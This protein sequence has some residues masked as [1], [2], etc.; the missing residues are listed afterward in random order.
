MSR[1][2]ER[3]ATYGTR[4]AR[5]P[6]SAQRRGLGQVG[7]GVV[8]ALGPQV[9][10]QLAQDRAR[11]VLLEDRHRVDAGERGEDRGA[12]VLLDQ[13]ALRALEPAHGRVG[14]QAHDQAVAERPR[15]LERAHVAGVQEVEA[16]ARGHHR[17]ALGADARGQ[18]G[19][20]LGRRRARPG[21]VARP[22]GGAARGDEGG[23]G[24]HGRAHGLRGQRAG[25][26]PRGGGRGE[27]VA[28]AAGSP[29][30]RAAAGTASAGPSAPTS[31][32]PRAPSVTHTSTARQ[33]S[34]SARA[35]VS[36]RAMPPR[37]PASEE[38]APSPAA[39]TAA[40]PRT[41]ASMRRR[42]ALGPR[43][44]G[45]ARGLGGVRRDQQ[46]AGTGSGPR[47]CGSQTTR[48]SAQRGERRAQPRLGGHAAAVV[49][50]EH[51][52]RP[53]PSAASGGRAERAAARGLA[54]VVEPHERAAAG[55]HAH[56]LGRRAHAGRGRRP[57]R[58][59]R[60]SSARSARRPPRR[61]RG[62]RR[63]SRVPGGRRQRRGKAG[64]ARAGVLLQA[65][66]HRH[67]R[68]GREPLGAA[69][70][71]A[72]EQHVADDGEPRSPAPP[73]ATRR[74]GAAAARRRRTA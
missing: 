21:R 33:R 24:G 70:E 40:C 53:P 19:G 69:V 17:A 54:A 50:D 52:R 74:A 2:V 14:V 44:R 64:A 72:V 13:R 71:V 49:G 23:G 43:V 32:A 25:G 5:P 7:D 56:L 61:R 22:G 10:P 66:D 55:A 62:R 3:P 11:V 9:R 18:R 38:V 29:A 31:S 12:V 67:G 8:A 65:V 37:T 36:W 1:V 73:P 26:E 68:V 48:P 63:A 58:R 45:E 57:R 34:R 51:A 46:A 30:P 59:P 42:L 35:R 20:V 16:A 28:G 41:S 6:H 27:A 4:T 39:E 47:G 60:P 15:R